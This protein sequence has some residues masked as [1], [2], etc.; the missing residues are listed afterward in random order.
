MEAKLSPLKLSQNSKKA[1]LKKVPEQSFE[2]SPVKTGPQK[3]IKK[4]PRNDS[5]QGPDDV[6]EHALNGKKF[7]VTGVFENVTRE[8]LER[9]IN[10]KGGRVTSAVSGVTNYLI[11]GTKLEDGRDVETSGKYRK[12]STLKVPILGEVEFEQLVRKMTGLERF[13]FGSSLFE[14][15]GLDAEA[16]GDN[17]EGNEDKKNAATA[18][19]KAGLQRHDMWT[20]AYAPKSLHDLVGNQGA[21][22][23]LFEWLRD[24]DDVHVR[25]NKKQ[26]APV[27]RFSRSAW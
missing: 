14:E 17:L 22:K 4:A 18:S 9:F 11:A 23:S 6:D 16:Y 1:K 27:N 12:A 2:D 13:S 24:W 26:L 10:T 21:I 20:D 15:A 7:A 19:N 5:S 8:E 25:G 3:P